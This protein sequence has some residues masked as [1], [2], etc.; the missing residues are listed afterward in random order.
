[1]AKHKQPVGLKAALEQSVGAKRKPR[2]RSSRIGE[3]A[4]NPLG[5]CAV[6]KST[7]RFPHPS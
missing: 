6:V 5:K 1:M 4:R 7:Q 3:A 2:K